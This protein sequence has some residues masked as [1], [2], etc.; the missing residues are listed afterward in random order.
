MRRRVV[1]SSL[2]QPS[3][4]RKTLFPGTASPLDSGFQNQWAGCVENVENVVVVEGGVEFVKNYLRLPEIGEIA[5][6]MLLF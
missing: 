6:L 2:P 4:R 1:Y 3:T 5:A